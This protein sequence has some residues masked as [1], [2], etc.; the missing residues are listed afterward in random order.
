MQSLNTFNTGSADANFA[1]LAI[2]GLCLL[3]IPLVVFFQFLNMMRD[4]KRVRHILEGWNKDGLPPTISPIVEDV[5]TEK[6]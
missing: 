6:E 4:V 1:I 5:I 3:A 2:I